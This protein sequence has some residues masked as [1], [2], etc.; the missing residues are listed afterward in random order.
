MLVEQQS[1]LHFLSR[2]TMTACLVFWSTI[3]TQ[4]AAVLPISLVS[5]LETKVIL[6]V[7]MLVYLI[8]LMNIEPNIQFLMRPRILSIWVVSASGY[9]GVEQQFHTAR[10]LKQV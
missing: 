10:M 5:L 1:F 9:A 4:C 6:Y 2:G 8:E 3:H 7:S